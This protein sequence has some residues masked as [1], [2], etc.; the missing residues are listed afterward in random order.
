MGVLPG[1][2][3]DRGR[4]PG[5]LVMTQAMNALAAVVVAAAVAE[6]LGPTRKHLKGLSEGAHCTGSCCTDTLRVRSRSL[7]AAHRSPGCASAWA[8]PTVRMSAMAC[9]ST[10]MVRRARLGA[11]RSRPG[12]HGSP[13]VGRC[14]R[15]ATAITAVTAVWT[16]CVGLGLLE[17]RR[18][19]ER[20]RQD[21]ALES[22]LSR[23]L[24]RPPNGTLDKPCCG[25]M[26]CCMGRG[27]NIGAYG[28]AGGAKDGEQGPIL[29]SE[30]QAPLRASYHILNQDMIAE[31]SLAARQLRHDMDSSSKTWQ[32]HFYGPRNL[33]NQKPQQVTLLG[34]PPARMRLQT[35]MSMVK[36]EPSLHESCLSRDT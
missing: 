31:N 33:G 19:S 23:V 16:E 13:P 30:M 6:P 4:S 12:S 35:N 15:T 7:S 14:A 9:L 28:A 5:L 22:L 18:G 25:G 34:K 11:R 24:L 29:G 36:R 32:P 20:R 2:S 17:R 26:P 8:A 3:T 21:R 27:T 10:P 1:V